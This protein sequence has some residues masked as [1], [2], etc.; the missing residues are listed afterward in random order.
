MVDINVILTV[1]K[2][3]FSSVFTDIELSTISTLY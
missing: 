3:I 1:D 2:H